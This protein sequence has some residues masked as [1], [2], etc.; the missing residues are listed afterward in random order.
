MARNNTPTTGTAG[1]SA[2]AEPVTTKAGKMTVPQIKAELDAR[3]VA[4]SD[5]D[6]KAAL[7]AMLD[8]E[9]AKE[10]NSNENA[11]DLASAG[12]AG[13]EATL[14][15]AIDKNPAEVNPA[16]PVQTN[17]P[18]AVSVPKVPV[19]IPANKPIPASETHLTIGNPTVK[20]ANQHTA[21]II[22]PR[23]SMGMNLPPTVLQAGW[24]NEIPADVWAKASKNPVVQSYL[25]KGLLAVVRKAGG[26]VPVLSET[27]TDLPIPEHLQDAPA[28]GDMTQAKVSKEKAGTVNIR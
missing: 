11:P 15:P 21:S 18:A 12:V 20:I 16:A 17:T 7:Q 27:S 23:R 3:G 1:A 24:V 22:L 8:N 28:H 5:T 13:E 14:E 6:L 9:L 26:T 19:A 4:Y 10:A 25:N 2:P